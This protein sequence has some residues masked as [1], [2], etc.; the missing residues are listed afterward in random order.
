MSQVV[1][2]PKKPKK[3]GCPICK[4]P[5]HA[6]FRPFCSARCKDEDMRRWLDG[7][8]RIPTDETPDEPQ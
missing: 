3:S 2:L 6:D 5:A 4:R 1:P 7:A 8:Y